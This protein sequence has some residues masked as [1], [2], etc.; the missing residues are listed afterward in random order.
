MDWLAAGITVLLLLGLCYQ[1]ILHLDWVFMV[2]Q[3][4]FSWLLD[5]VMRHIP[6]GC[7]I[8]IEN[9]IAWWICLYLLS[10]LL[11][12]DMGGP[13][14]GWLS[15]CAQ[16]GFRLAGAGAVTAGKGM[17]SLFQAALRS[18]QPKELPRSRRD[19]QGRED[20]DYGP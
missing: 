20:E 13:F 17:V 15:R 12:K 4:A 19:K 18:A 3:N 8:L 14:R 2:G 16:T 6:A 11:P 7:Y 1:S 5:L 10:H 9:L